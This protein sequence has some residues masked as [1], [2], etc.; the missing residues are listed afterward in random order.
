MRLAVATVLSLLT[1]GIAGAS[2]VAFASPALADPPAATTDAGVANY[3]LQERCSND[4]VAFFE[5]QKKLDAEPNP[6]LTAEANK[7]RTFVFDYENNYSESEK[8]CFI[9]MTTMEFD[10][11]DHKPDSST[12]YALYNVTTHHIVGNYSIWR[13]DGKNQ[14]VADTCEFNGVKCSSEAEW[15]AKL[16]PYIPAAKQNN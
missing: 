6:I 16:A 14:F 13:R 9:L 1:S 5:R 3:Q 11:V 8:G 12:L 15:W 2:V 7:D 10:D 4:A